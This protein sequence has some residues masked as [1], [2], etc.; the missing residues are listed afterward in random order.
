MTAKQFNSL[1]ARLLNH[2]FLTEDPVKRVYWGR[3]FVRLVSLVR[4][5]H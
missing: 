4:N 2:E 5:H 3:H 1:A